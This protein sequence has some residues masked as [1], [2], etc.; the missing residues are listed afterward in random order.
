MMKNII[1]VFV[2]GLIAITSFGQGTELTLEDAVM[3]QYRKFA[4]TSLIMLAQIFYT[5][6]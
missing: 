2:I 3:Q 1:S 6:A 5:V 4:P